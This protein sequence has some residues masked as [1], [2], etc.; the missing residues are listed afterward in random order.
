[1]QDAGELAVQ[2]EIIEHMKETITYLFKIIWE[3]KER[4][5]STVKR[6]KNMQKIN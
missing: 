4:A 3:I 1:M 5:E 6:W 2:E